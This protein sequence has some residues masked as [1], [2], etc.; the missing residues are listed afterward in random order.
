MS[1]AS[2]S[3]SAAMTPGSM[4]PPS[5]AAAGGGVL[6]SGA[7]AVRGGNG[8]AGKRRRAGACVDRGG[9]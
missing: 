5:R 2:G 1:T 3:A 8:Y 6:G 7:G 4:G 9:A